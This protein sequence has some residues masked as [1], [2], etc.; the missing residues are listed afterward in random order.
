MIGNDQTVVGRYMSKLLKKEG[1]KTYVIMHGSIDS[2]LC[3]KMIADRFLVYGERDKKL[4][5]LWGIDIEKV[6]VVG[7]PQIDHLIN[8][9]RKVPEKRIQ[10]FLEDKKAILIATSGP[11]HS[12]SEPNHRLVCRYLMDLAKTR[13]DYHFIVKLHRKD[14][15]HFYEEENMSQKEKLPKNVAIIEYQDQRFD[16]SIY[17]WLILAKAMISVASSAIYDAIVM[18]KPVI[19]I[20]PL[21]E[22]ADFDAIEKKI[23]IHNR[24][25]IELKKNFDS[26]LDDH[27]VLKEQLAIQKEYKVDCFANHETGDASKIIAKKLLEA[28]LLIDG[29]V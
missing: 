20:D 27:E 11:G 14:R 9:E 4:L 23:T 1:I 19:T 29:E 26:L 5:K 3:K 10:Q 7:S 12:V 28:S 6:L 8:K 17:E 13:M 21:N 24:N 25:F 22:C 16:N 18:D 2:F 15:R